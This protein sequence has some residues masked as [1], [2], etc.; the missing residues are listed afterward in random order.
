MTGAVNMLIDVTEEQTEALHEQAKR[1]R[2]LASSLYSR[3]SSIVL[4]TMAEQ[5]ERTAAELQ[6]QQ[7]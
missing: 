5:F 6:Q 4:E 3:E 7:G 1:C 2:R